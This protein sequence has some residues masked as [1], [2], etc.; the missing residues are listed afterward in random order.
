MSS[1]LRSTAK[2][3]VALEEPAHNRHDVDVIDDRRGDHDG[4]ELMREAQAAGC[5]GLL[6]DEC[7]PSPLF[8]EKS[9][10]L[11]PPAR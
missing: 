3:E 6:G 1:R 11:Q 7:R 5:T 2:Y 4:L 8:H 9:L 10:T